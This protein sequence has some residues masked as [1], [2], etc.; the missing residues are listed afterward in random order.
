MEKPVK[1]IG[2]ATAEQIK[3]WK[4]KYGSVYQ[5]ISI[6]EDG[7]MH[8]TYVKKPDL[9]VIAASA[10][11]AQDDP[12]QSGEIMVNSIRLGG[13]DTVPGDLNMMLGLFEKIGELTKA[14]QTSLGK[15]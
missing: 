6:D 7:N 12:I 10:K 11:V 9:D 1:E 4:A 14:A 3:Q 2:K 8:Y 13:S 5:F 15:L